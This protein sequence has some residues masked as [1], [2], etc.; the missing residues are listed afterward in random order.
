MSTL[1]VA[2]REKASKVIA[3]ALREAKNCNVLGYNDLQAALN[4]LEDNFSKFNDAH[5]AVMAFCGNATRDFESKIPE[6][7]DAAY[8]EAKSLL[9]S[10]INLKKSTMMKQQVIQHRHSTLNSNLLQTPTVQ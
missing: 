4:N 5:A 7:V 1:A 10:A 9:L 8:N 3:Q 6:P 2:N